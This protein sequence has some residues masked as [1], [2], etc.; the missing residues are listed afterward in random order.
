MKLNRTQQIN[1][2]YFLF[3]PYSRE[4]NKRKIVT[5]WSNN[6]TE[7]NWCEQIALFSLFRSS[8]LSSGFC[9]TDWPWCHKYST[10]SSFTRGSNFNLKQNLTPHTRPVKVKL[11][12]T[13]VFFRSSPTELVKKYPIKHRHVIILGSWNSE[14]SKIEREGAKYTKVTSPLTLGLIWETN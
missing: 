7:L 14:K 12:G 1:S 5:F 2:N 3:I 13:L 6:W 11:S 8:C 4:S 9:L 10:S